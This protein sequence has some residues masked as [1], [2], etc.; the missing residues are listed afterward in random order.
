[1]NHIQVRIHASTQ[2][3]EHFSIYAFLGPPPRKAP[4]QDPFQSFS[5]LGFLSM[6]RLYTRSLNQVEPDKVREQLD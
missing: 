2:L 3:I 1:M 4:Q 5:H 6:S